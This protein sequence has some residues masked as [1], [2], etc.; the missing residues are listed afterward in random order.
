MHRSGLTAGLPRERNGTS[1]PFY[2]RDTRTVDWSV[3]LQVGP[4]SQKSLLKLE[5]QAGQI[6]LAQ[7]KLM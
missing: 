2:G 3:F 1:A 6:R 5:L 4:E 7:G